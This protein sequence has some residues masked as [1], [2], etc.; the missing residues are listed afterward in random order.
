MQ[1]SRPLCVEGKLLNLAACALTEMWGFQ[2]YIYR[3]M[4]LSPA[5]VI[6]TSKWPC[7]GRR[8]IS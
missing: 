5:V 6:D 2:V 3:H 7:S 1:K 8:G 4:L